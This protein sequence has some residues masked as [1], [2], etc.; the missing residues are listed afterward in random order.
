MTNRFAGVNTSP[1]LARLQA[2]HM[3]NVLRDMPKL[4]FV[5]DDYNGDY[6][7]GRTDWPG[8]TFNIVSRAEFETFRKVYE[9]LNMPLID[10]D[11]VD[12][13]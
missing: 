12:E 2:Q 9:A 4:Y 1:R 11:E 7:V 3:E 8:D 10:Q 6:R 5:R 13:I